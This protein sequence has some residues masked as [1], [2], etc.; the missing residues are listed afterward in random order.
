MYDVKSRDVGNFTKLIIEVKY[1][2]CIELPNNNIKKG[3]SFMTTTQLV[4]EYKDY[5]VIIKT[6]YMRKKQK[7]K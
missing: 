5:S 1:I 2:P 3:K 4:V 7:L 6:F